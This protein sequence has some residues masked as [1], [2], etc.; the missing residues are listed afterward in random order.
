MKTI[1]SRCRFGL[2]KQASHEGYELPFNIRDAAILASLFRVKFRK[3]KN[4]KTS[5][6]CEVLADTVS[7]LQARV[8]RPMPQGYIATERTSLL[9]LFRGVKGAVGEKIFRYL[10][11]RARFTP[12]VVRI[13]GQDV[14][15][16]LQP[17]QL[18]TR[19]RQIEQDIGIAKST[20]AV[21]LK[22]LEAEGLI[23]RQVYP[24]TAA[25]A[26]FTVLTI[27]R[28]LLSGSPDGTSSSNSGSSDAS[29]PLSAG[30]PPPLSAGT[31]EKNPDLLKNS[32]LDMAEGEGKGKT[33]ETSTQYVSNAGEKPEVGKEPERLHGESRYDYAMRLHRFR[34]GKGHDERGSLGGGEGAAGLGDR[35]GHAQAGTVVHEERRAN[36]AKVYHFPD[37]PRQ[38]EELGA[39]RAGGE[40]HGRA[41]AAYRAQDREADRSA[42][43]DAI[44]G[45]AAPESRSGSGSGENG[46]NDRGGDESAG[47][48]SGITQDSGEA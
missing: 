12:G 48:L 46:G 4:L 2:L 29:S 31:D 23:V 27:V 1:R 35:E 37:V 36:S 16:M 33:A 18:W 14:C 38:R 17:G 45:G 22:R 47:D 25:G 7:A 5:N 34:E 15:L 13:Y 24:S 10:C 40:D 28:H 39:D 20:V 9:P 19:T 30:N 44:A 42:A 8:K 41:R 32:S 6:T 21:W 11:E 43:W 26:G 3:G